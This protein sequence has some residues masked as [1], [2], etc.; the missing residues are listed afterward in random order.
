MHRKS[1]EAQHTLRD[2]S[3]VSDQE[4]V[5]L[6]SAGSKSGD[7]LLQQQRHLSS[8]NESLN[9]VSPNLSPPCTLASL[10]HSLCSPASTPTPTATST[11]SAS[12][13][14]DLGSP[15]PNTQQMQQQHN[16]SNSSPL[17]QYGNNQSLNRLPPPATLP[18]HTPS[19][20]MSTASAAA[21]PSYHPLLD[22]ANASACAG[23]ASTKDFHMI[24][25]TAVAAAAA[26]A[27]HTNAGE[28]YGSAGLVQDPDTFRYVFDNR[29]NW[30][31]NLY[32]H[33]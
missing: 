15:S 33:I 27:A 29:T 24:M 14:I 11:S 3:G 4:E 18:N 2:D 6:E 19:V 30:N 13:H 23:A 25:N 16:L 31:R 17:Q 5:D 22:A 28:L 21:T 20:G 1:I 9:V 32:S 26:V 10:H 7:N 12:P 8:S